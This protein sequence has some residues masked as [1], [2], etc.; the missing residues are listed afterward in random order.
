MGLPGINITFKEQGV[1]AITRSQR[2][3]VALILKDTVPGTNPVT[4][5]TPNEIPKD[6]NDFNKEQINLAL[7]GY[8]TPPKKIIAYVLPEDAED[9]TEAQNYFETVRWDYVAVP[10][11]AEG[12]VMSFAAWVKG[13]RDTKNKKVKAVLPN[14]AADHEGIINFTT[15]AIATG[16][17]TTYDSG[18]GY[19]E[20]ETYAKEYSTAEYCSRIAGMI[21]GT[22]LTISCTFA[23]LPEVIDCNKM[24][25]EELDEAIDKGELVLYNDGEKIKIARGVNSLVTTTE[26]KL[27]S[28]KKIKI[29]EAMDLMYDDIKK[30]AEDNYLG[31]YSN[32]YDNKC[33]LISAILGY[34]EGLEIDGILNRGFSE[35]GIDMESQ[36]AFLKSIGYKTND[37]RTVDE[38]NELEIKNADTKDKVFLYAKVKILDAI[39]E[40]TLNVSL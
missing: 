21:A 40:I 34:L 26:G 37:G 19:D 8:Q 31:K 4:I 11:I 32:S 35:V 38:M 6:L 33:L 24:T 13:L 3:I 23:P 36:T 2:G 7:I 16:I 29:V 20:G 14:C 27:D 9:Y 12:E 30:T 28:F 39:E 10:A 22:P 5:T 15:E 1:T 17:A 18:A 25:T